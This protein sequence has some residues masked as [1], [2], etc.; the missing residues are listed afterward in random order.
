MI[1]EIRSFSHGA[2]ES[3]H[4]YI[5]WLFPMRTRSQFNPYAPILDDDTVHAFLMDERLRA[6]LLTSFRVRLDFYG[7][8][9]EAP[10]GAPVDVVRSKAWAERR[11]AWLSP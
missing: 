2:L 9:L 4:D 6:E 7:F 1:S 3:T 8:R 11:R 10:R 5:Q